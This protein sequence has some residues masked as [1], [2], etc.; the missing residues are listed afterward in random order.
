MIA[1][2]YPR[3]P[4][5]TSLGD[6]QEKAPTLEP[7]ALPEPVGELSFKLAIMKFVS[8]A[9]VKLLQELALECVPR[10][11]STGTLDCRGTFPIF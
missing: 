11:R 9:V 10:T 3:L 5:P 7:A 8:G 2:F 4:F 6:A 1:N